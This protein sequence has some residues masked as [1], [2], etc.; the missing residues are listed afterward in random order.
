[1]AEEKNTEEKIDF[2]AYISKYKPYWWILLIGLVFGLGMSLLYLKI[3]S[4]LFLTK[5]M[6]MVNQDE[7]ESAGAVGGLGALMSSF[8]LGGGGGVNVEDEMLKISSHTNMKSVINDLHLNHTYWSKPGLF[9]RKIWYYNDSPVKIEIPNAVLDTITVITLFD[10]DFSKDGNKISIEVE[11]GEE[12]TIYETTTNK[13]PHIVKT[14]YGTFTIDTTGYFIKGEELNF[15]ASI[16]NPDVT[17]EDIN[18]RIAITQLSK[19]ANAIQ[20]DLEDVNTTR[21]QDFINTL[22]K[23][24][25]ERG[26]ADK[27]EQALNTSKFIDERLVQLYNELESAEIKIEDY[28]RDNQIVDA[29]AEAEFIFRKKETMEAALIEFE[30][31]AAVL[32]MIKDFLLSPKNKYSLVP[33]T[34]DF[35]E[36]PISA[37]NELILQRINLLT[38]AKQNNATLKNLTAQI[39]AMRENVITTIEKQLQSTQI[40]INDMS[41]EAS[42]SKNRMEGIPKMERELTA[43]YRDQVIKNEIY[44]YLLQKREENQLKLMR[45]TPKGKVIDTAHTE[46]EPVS[47]NKIVVPALGILFGL[48]MG[49]FGANIFDKRR[50]RKNSQTS[51][52]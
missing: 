14:P 28:K 35:P 4:P 1:M 9:D 25:N 26:L 34:A 45:N 43:L 37:Y 24:Y 11:Q 2:G 5:S 22:V 49:I 10:I 52:E 27:N 32:K 38:N 15:K 46:V 44:G 19:K 47:P 41:R 31:K 13:M 50:R 7:E 30:T 39:D 6:V 3:K 48:G 20:I 16:C 40:A 12:G 17:I 51:I 21:A 42:N 8:S 18:E 36:E 23:S 29:T 33:F